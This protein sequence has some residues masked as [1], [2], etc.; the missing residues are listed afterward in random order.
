MQALQDK[1]GKDIRIDVEIPDYQVCVDKFHFSNVLQNLLDNAVKYT[2]SHPHIV[3]KAGQKG[4]NTWISVSDNG[5]GI[6][7]SQRKRV[8]EKYYR[9]P[10]G[11]V[12]N[13]RGFG[14]GLYYCR[15]VVEK[16]GGKISVSGSPEG[17]T[18]VT[19]LF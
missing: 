16:H 5:M 2:P 13:V 18:T 6:P 14:I 9:I 4:R 12:Q 3:L 15:L 10:T 7:S 19:I 17:G 1:Y 8:F 11:D